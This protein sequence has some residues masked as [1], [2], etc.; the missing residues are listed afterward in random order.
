MEDPPIVIE[1]EALVDPGSLVDPNVEAFVETNDDAIEDGTGSKLGPFG[2]S[3]GPDSEF[4]KIDWNP[5]VPEV[6]FV[7]E[8]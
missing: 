4:K 6:G 1:L 5:V 8:V 2:F 3:G 7:G